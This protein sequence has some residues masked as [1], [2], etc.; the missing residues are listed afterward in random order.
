M[1]ERGSS[2]RVSKSI[3]SSSSG[4]RISFSGTA[5]QVE[6]TFQTQLHRYQINGVAHM[7]NATEISVP[8][9]ISGMV[10][11][12]RNLTDFRPQPRLREP[13]AHYTASNGAHYLTPDDFTTIYDVKAQYNAGYTGA[14]E[15]IAVVGQ[16]AIL[17]SDI[18]TFRSLTG[19]PAS[20]PTMT[21]VPNTGTSQTFT[22]DETESDIDVE[23]SGAVAKNATINFVYVGNSSNASVFDA[24]E[25]AVENDL[26][27]VISISYGACEAYSTSDVS[28]LQPFFSQ[29]NAQ[30][31]TIVGTAGDN[32]A[33][34]C[35]Q[36]QSTGGT[37]VNGDEA[38][39]GPA[40]DFPGSSPNVTSMG[41]TEFT[42]ST[43][44]Y[45]NSTN[46]SLGGS[47]I[48]FIPAMVWNDTSTTNGPTAGGG[49]KSILFGKPVW[50]VGTGVPSDGARDVPDLA[51]NA[52][53]DHD[54]YLICSTD[55]DS[56][57]CSN[58]FADS[59]GNLTVYG[60]TSFAAPT[61]AGLL[62]LINQQVAP[63][64]QG[65]V[66]PLIY[67]IANSDSGATAY[68][69]VTTGNNDI[70]CV[71]GSPGCTGGQFGYSAT[72]G[73][74][75]A[76]GWGAV[77]GN[78]LAQAF[79][80][81]VAAAS[82]TI[83]PTTTVLTSS[84]TAP[85]INTPVTFTATVSSDSTSATPTG[86]V[87][88]AINGTNSGGPVA[89]AT[90]AASLPNTFTASGSY[91]ITA[92]YSG[93]STHSGSTASFAVTVSASSKPVGSLTLSAT[94]PA[95]IA[96]GS[97]ATSTITATPSGGYTGTV[98]LTASAPS[99]L[100]ACYTSSPA[101]VTGTTAATGS[102][103]INTSASACASAS[104]RPLSGS[105]P[106]IAS[107]S[108]PGNERR[109]L[110]GAGGVAL[111]SVLLLGFS[112]KRKRLGSALLGSVLLGAALLGALCSGVGCGGGSSSNSSS[113]TSTSATS[114]YPI[115]VTATDALT[116]NTLN[117]TTFTLTVQ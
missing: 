33:A 92:T 85:V 36:D 39:L 40:V 97:S 71:T 8:S 112:R 22:G 56:T 67:A 101:V 95:S 38:S 15:T 45:W 55:A 73:Y 62:T 24:L 66:N 52:S 50:Q 26:A 59:K 34:D 114:N 49:G 100:S 80:T 79:A 60:G 75:L 78:N 106:K 93:D 11:G 1:F 4:N 65:N 25:Y 43:G 69:D 109:S 28:A 6:N 87:Q 30:G 13:V 57:S 16:S 31:Q 64:G 108:T 47:A 21:L 99:T 72:T 32:G 18:A 103:T 84:A 117:T 20:A 76:S 104:A 27:P 113:S 9:A 98:V 110:G 70:P 83:I 29:A 3:A 96:S 90:G 46:N 19:L 41:G 105:A 7:A 53:A 51:L 107:R 42:D 74:D 77:D 23:W 88:F 61:F 44:N 111:A 115:T 58:S 116:G 17:A 89:L 48:G 94:T 5:A 63:K 82:P 54:G 68:H 12:V 102:I 91:T 2:R 10:A 37:V 35:D 14:G 86:T 81:Q